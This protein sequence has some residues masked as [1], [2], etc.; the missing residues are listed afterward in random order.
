MNSVKVVVLGVIIFSLVA[1]GKFSSDQN[2]N[3]NSEGRDLAMVR[4]SAT[5]EPAFPGAMGF[6]KVATGGRGGKVLKVTNLSDSVSNPSPGSLRWA[7]NQSGKRIIIFETGGIIRLNKAIIV[8]N[9]DLTI[10][11]QTAP[12]DGI[13]LRGARLL[14]HASNVIVRGM[15]FRP[16]DD[17][18]G[19]IDNNGE[20]VDAD[21]SIGEHPSENR[22]GI[23]IGNDNQY[24]KNVI[25]D[26]NSAQWSIDESMTAWGNL[27]NITFSHNLFAEAL[28]DSFHNTRD[29]HSMG[30][31]IGQAPVNKQPTWTAPRRVTAVRNVGSNSDYRCPLVNR[32]SQVEI[33]NNYCWNFVN[34]V[35][36]GA[37]SEA[38][39]IKNY[40]DHGR[41]NR[42]SSPNDPRPIQLASTRNKWY[43]E[44]NLDSEFRTS[45]SMSNTTNVRGNKSLQSS[46]F[47]TG[48]GVPELPANQL[49]GILLD[50]VG[51]RWP[52]RDAVDDR[53][54]TEIKDK[55]SRRVDK[56][57]QVG[58]WGTVRQGTAPK[59]SDGDGMPDWF[60]DAMGLNKND[61]SDVNGDK[62]G[63]GYKNI[64]EYINGIITGFDFEDGGGNGGVI[65]GANPAIGSDLY[66]E[67]EDMNL[68]SGF[69]SQALAD[70]AG[71]VI[72]TDTDVGNASFLFDQPDGYYRFRIRYFDENDGAAKM[73]ILV[74]G[75]DVD[76]WNWNTNTGTSIAVQQARKT[77]DSSNILL[78]TGDIVTLQGTPNGGEPVRT[79]YVRL[80]LEGQAPVDID[81]VIGNDLYIEAE[82]MDLVSGFTVFNEVT[83]AAGGVIQTESTGTARFLF[84]QATGYYRVR[85]RYFDEND[86]V[87]NARVLI[88]GVEAFSWSWNKNLGA[89]V[90]NAQTRTTITQ[91][92]VYIEGGSV[93]SIEATAN[94]GE[95]ARI[96]Y[97][98]MFAVQPDSGTDP[99]SDPGTTPVPSGN[100]KIGSD[101][102]IEAE[103]MD[104]LSGFTTENVSAASGGV[105]LANTTGIARFTFD[106]PTG[107]YKFRLEYFDENDGSANIQVLVNGG[108]AFS[109]NLNKNLGSASANSQTKTTFTSGDIN[110]P[111]GSAVLIIAT[112]NS[113]EQVRIDKVTM[114]QGD[115][116]PSDSTPTPA[117]EPSPTPTTPELV[118]DPAGRDY[119]IEA[120]A[121]QLIGDYVIIPHGTASGSNIIEASTSGRA[122]YVFNGVRGYYRIRVA[123]YDENDGAASMDI[124][125]NNSIIHSWTWNEDRGSPIANT[126]TRTTEDKD[127]V[128]LN[129]G[130]VIDLRGVANGNE[131]ARLDYFRLFYIGTPQ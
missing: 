29:D 6:G 99:G 7:V 49:K 117:P 83:D 123:Y 121:T 36:T 73:R 75:Q 45:N 40:Y 103:T 120:E 84:D 43:L 53:I 87:A 82:D 102:S 19:R 97:L 42:L 72:L 56:T 11:G 86:G 62:D 109:F 50:E 110:V 70:A 35:E 58:G 104:L 32:A 28:R 80:F 30:L 90:A 41:N 33:I 23:S 21:P 71:S 60:E 113:G 55:V 68:I 63:D 112:S 17:D 5:T 31:L 12:G 125:I 98:R 127:R 114:F 66:I 16:G 22:D 128:L 89:S 9:G 100:A 59:D 38:H 18:P 107:N 2:L 39:F 92:N 65:V 95:P 46:R 51:A 47:F 93:I 118:I 10:A 116:P 13:V 122:R 14:I 105:I 27:E 85:L 3:Q 20:R 64:E 79:D 119:Y 54:I 94:S 131:L 115:A 25:V 67:A 126:Q 52:Q 106:Q 8:K 24:I 124:R 129:P 81:Q 96:D 26:H 37:D 61:K 88:N 1:C 101:L 76:G 34:F 15:R 111:K 77:W 48:S 74:N 91:E 108:N 4:Q 57:N 44:G 78:R 69:Y 130:D